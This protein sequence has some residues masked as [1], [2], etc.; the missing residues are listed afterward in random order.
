MERSKENENNIED[1]FDGLLYKRHF[2]SQGFFHG[3]TQD[4]LDKEIH[5][6][7][8]LNTDGVAIFKSNKTSMWPVYLV[9]NELHP[10][11]RL[12]PVVPFRTCSAK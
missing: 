7:F 8:Q 2:N 3:T 4:R 11:L 10:K 1:V 5:L 12:V 9:I 6:S